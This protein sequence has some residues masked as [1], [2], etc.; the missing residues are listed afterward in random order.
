[1]TSLYGPTQTDASA[2]QSVDVDV[3]AALRSCC[4][5]LMHLRLLPSVLSIVLISIVLVVFLGTWQRGA[6]TLYAYRAAGVSRERLAT[7]IHPAVGDLAM[8][9]NT[10]TIS[11]TPTPWPTFTPTP[12]PTATPEPATPTPLPFQQAQATV[13]L[14]GMRHEWQTWNNCGPATIAMNLSYFGSTIDQAQAGAV[15]RLSADD[16]NVSPHELV[17]YAQSQGY[18][19][20]RLVNGSTDLARTLLSN[21][22]PVLVETWYEDK[23]NDGLGHY[24]LLVGYDDAT[25]SWTVY[26]S[27]DRSNLI[28][29]EPYGGLRFSFAEMDNLWKVFNRAFVLAY[30][31]DRAAVVDAILGAYNVIPQT[32]YAAAAVQAQAELTAN[33]TDAFAWFNLG[34]S[35][36]A[37]GQ[38][39]EAAAAFDQAR[40]IGLPW[41][42]FWYQFEI[43]DAYLALGRAQEAVALADQ[44]NAITT[45]IE[46]IHYWRGRALAML[47][48]TLGASQAIQQALALNPTFGPAQQAAADLSS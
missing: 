47:G 13:L 7:P 16:K 44:V 37:Q 26:D 1:M 6:A 40:T 22:I 36:T 24:R 41:R 8:P 9:G 38:Y 23:P 12:E 45:S 25:Q 5:T 19:S 32:M 20:Q 18:V 21:G 42:M 15:L 33:P 46:E 48:D 27:Y 30:P 2:I 3:R 17:T 28:S 31:P 43:F 10:P 35:L 4:N 29:V 11:P 14:T 39:G 34:S